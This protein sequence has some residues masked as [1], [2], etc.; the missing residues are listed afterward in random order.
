MISLIILE[1]QQCKRLHI[2]DCATQ[3]PYSEELNFLMKCQTLVLREPR[4]LWLCV[5]TL[6]EEFS[7]QAFVEESDKAP[8][9]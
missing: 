4:G 8:V 7:T 5:K 6:E 2:L 3:T 1:L 9:E